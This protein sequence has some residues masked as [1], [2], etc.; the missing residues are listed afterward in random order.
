MWY[1]SGMLWLIDFEAS[2]RKV[3]S[4]MAF[5]SLIPFFILSPWIYIYICPVF[6]PG[7]ASG[8]EALNFLQLYL[9]S[10]FPNVELFLYT[11]SCVFKWYASFFIIFVF[12]WVSE[13]DLYFAYSY[14]SSELLLPH[15]VICLADPWFSK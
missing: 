3:F 7:N 14:V 8:W 1:D 10:F 9:I 12:L 4:L 5:T 11:W 6:S 15:H 2:C 13:T